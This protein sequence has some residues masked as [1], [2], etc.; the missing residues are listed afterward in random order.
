M[1][2][3]EIKSLTQTELNARLKELNME[4]FN[5]RFSNASR[6]LANPVQIR[7]VKREIARVKTVIREKELAGANGGSDGK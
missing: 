2:I 1:K 6:N 4:L 7:N 3:S 5:L